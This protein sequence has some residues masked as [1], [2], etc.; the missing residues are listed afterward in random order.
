[1]L[2]IHSK[3]A[4]NIITKKTIVQKQGEREEKCSFLR[5]IV[6]N[7]NEREIIFKIIKKKKNSL[8][9]SGIHNEEEISEK[10]RRK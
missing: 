9:Q 8:L 6:L 4:L 7:K 2:K 5:V 1:M 10:K 3:E